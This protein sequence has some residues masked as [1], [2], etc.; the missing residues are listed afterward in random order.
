MPQFLKVALRFFALSAIVVGAVAIYL[1]RRARLRRPTA[2]RREKL[3]GAVLAETLQRSGAAFIKL[4][5]ILSTRPDLLGPGYIEHL[6][7]LQDQVP[8]APFEAVR[9]L[10]ERELAAEHRARLAEIEPTPVAAASVAQVHRAR[11][12][13]GEELALKL[14]RPGVEALIERDLAL[15]GLFAR[16][17]NLI[18]TVRL[19]DIPG[20]IRE[21]GVALRGQ[22]DFLREAENNRR[23][24]ENFR[25]V[26]HVRVPRL[27]EPLCTP[28]V[29]AMEFVEGVRATEP[30][31]VG[32]DPKVLA[33]RGSEAILKMVFLDGFVHADLHPGNIVL[34]ASD[35]VVLIDLG[36]VAEI[37]Q[38]MLR[39]WIET[40]AALAQQDGRKAARML[41]GYSPS[42]RIPDY[43]AYEREVE[44]YFE[45][46]YGLT[47]GQVEISTAVGGVLALLRRHRIKVDPVFTV[48]NIALLVA[49]GLGKQLDP[50]L[51]MT[52]LALPFL[53][54][55]IASAPPGRPPYRRPPASAEVTE[56]VV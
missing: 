35:E 34:T 31:R 24:A 36:M 8:P 32:G 54:Q 27:F 48:V 44:S 1:W 56:D 38:D 33:R 6:Q 9:G 50:D 30:H 11:L 22:L 49:E 39:P 29:L 23:F 12:V 25:D 4:G 55:A 28:R 13:S 46:F 3:R 40:F 45:R 15:M 14:Q 43:A 26:P 19:L 37:P 2:S 41:Y 18:P 47:V 21:F 20:A 42:V 52:T 10:V 5:Q 53:G 51:D 16:M 17:L 7:K